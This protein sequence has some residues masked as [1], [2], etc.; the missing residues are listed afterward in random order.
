MERVPSRPRPNA[1]ERH[2]EAGFHHHAGYWVEDA[3]YSIPEHDARTLADSALTA[4]AVL[5]RSM[6]AVLK[7]SNRFRQ[8]LSVEGLSHYMSD[9][10][11]YSWE[12]QKQ[13]VCS[14]IR[15]GWNPDEGS[16]VL[17]G[18]KSGSALGMVEQAAQ[19]AWGADLHP[20][21]FQFANLD[22]AMSSAL[23]VYEG[24]PVHVLFPLNDDTGEIRS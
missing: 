16:P 14:R 10:I 15:L 1:P 22:R 23:S 24:I 17:L 7:D 19:Q 20:D 12:Q 11:I 21:E 8:L 3:Y 9:M 4:L 2:A 13:G 18:Y 6:S 5:E